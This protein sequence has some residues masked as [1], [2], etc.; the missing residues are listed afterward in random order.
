MKS[1]LKILAVF[2]L[3]CCGQSF[4]AHTNTY[5]RNIE[6]WS[7]DLDDEHYIVRYY[8]GKDLRSFGHLSIETLN[9]H[10][11]LY[12]SKSSGRVYFQKLSGDRVGCRGFDDVLLKYVRAP[13]EEIA[14]MEEKIS[15]L[16]GWDKQNNRMIDGLKTEYKERM[17]EYVDDNSIFA[18][19]SGPI[20]SIL[21]QCPQSVN[22]NT[23][24]VRRNGTLRYMESVLIA[25][26]CE[27][28]SCMF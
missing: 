2:W 25:V 22:S 23:Q 28:T 14:L 17:V 9:Y 1:S 7:D 26:G 19:C 15:S 27:K 16:G 6:K 3:L 12:F 8:K 5:H 20:A 13:R 11:S 21:K 24:A 18:S 10:F 4:A